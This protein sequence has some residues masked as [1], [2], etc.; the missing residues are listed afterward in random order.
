MTKH[1]CVDYDYMKF[2]EDN[3]GRIIYFCMFDQS[4]S[5]LEE[6]GVCCGCELDGFAEEL[7]CEQTDE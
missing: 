3:S 6:V 7:Y 4:D 2:L 1:D 5:Y